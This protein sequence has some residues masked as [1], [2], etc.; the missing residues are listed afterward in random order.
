MFSM[1]NKGQSTLEYVILLG[2]VVAALIA[3][4]IY[5]KRGSEGQL[6]SATDQVGE[7]YEA[8]NTTSNFTTTRYLV[9]TENQTAGGHVVTHIDQGNNITAKTGNETVNQW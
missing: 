9:Q 6:R 7:Q 3:M 1:K 5:M 4:G 8:R 2:F